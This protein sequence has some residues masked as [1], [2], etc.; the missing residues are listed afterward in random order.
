MAAKACSSLVTLE[1]HSVFG[2]LGAA[3]AEI[4]SE[5]Q[6]KRVMRI[7]VN[8]RFSANCGTYEYLLRE[9]GLDYTSISKQIVDFC[10][11]FSAA[12]A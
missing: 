4:V 11:T 12:E 6:A 3:V 9:H 8:D 2:G 7:G 5:H 1:E 10:M